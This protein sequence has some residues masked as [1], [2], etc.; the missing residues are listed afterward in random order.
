M[1]QC[2]SGNMWLLR[3]LQNAAKESVSP[4]NWC[5][6]C[7]ADILVLMC[8]GKKKLKR[9]KKPNDA[10]RPQG[11]LMMELN[12][13]HRS[14]QL[15]VIVTW[16]SWDKHIGLLCLE[17]KRCQRW[18]CWQGLVGAQVS[19]TPPM[20]PPQNRGWSHCSV[21]RHSKYAGGQSSPDRHSRYPD[22]Q[23]GPQT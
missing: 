1:V 4:N 14:L 16:N 7:R 12:P 10:L 6:D 15:K 11:I 5:S 2:H 23:S 20:F 22:G 9:R 18:S 13:S 19:V 21:H 17:T 3:C 8:S